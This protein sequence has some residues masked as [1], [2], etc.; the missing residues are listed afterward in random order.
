MIHIIMRVLK[1][2]EIFRLM[3]NNIIIVITT[4]DTYLSENCDRNVLY[5]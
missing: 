1:F 3:K 2:Y 4:A 5:T